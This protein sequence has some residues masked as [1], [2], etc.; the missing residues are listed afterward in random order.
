MPYRD[1]YDIL[2]Y[3]PN[4]RSRSEISL[5]QPSYQI[6]SSMR[7]YS[8]LALLH[9][10]K[11][12]G[13]AGSAALLIVFFRSLSPSP[14]WHTLAALLHLHKATVVAPTKD[15]ATVAAP[16]KDVAIV[17]ARTKATV[18]LT[19]PILLV[20]FFIFFACCQFFFV[21]VFQTLLHP[22]MRSA[23][24]LTTKAGAAL[25]RSAVTPFYA[26]EAFDL[27]AKR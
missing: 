6:S 13:V 26:D 22:F 9:L 19:I 27:N 3:I 23:A 17:A 10:P 4:A 15:V 18:A 2:F 20:F 25:M 1:R 12:S 7:K 16:T 24:A 5:L 21:H 11:A 8:Q 14:C